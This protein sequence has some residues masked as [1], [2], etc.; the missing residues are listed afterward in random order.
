M[1]M[2]PGHKLVYCKDCNSYNSWQPNPAKD[3]HGAETGKVLWYNYEC[4]VCGHATIIP[5]E[6]DYKDISVVM[7]ENKIGKEVSQ[8]PYMPNK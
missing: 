8:C 1:S 3:I 5:A 7:R 4:K 2:K 6:L